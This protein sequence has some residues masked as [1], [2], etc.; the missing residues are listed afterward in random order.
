MTQKKLNKI[1]LGDGDSKIFLMWEQHWLS[2]WD[3]LDD[4]DKKVLAALYWEL[5]SDKQKS[6]F[7]D[8][9]YIDLQK[10]KAAKHAELMSDP[11]K[12]RKN[13]LEGA[14]PLLD[15]MLQL[16]TG[17]KQNKSKDTDSEAWA[18][19]EIW[20]VLKD[21]IIKTDDLAPMLDLKGKSI[22]DQID[23]ILTKVSN[24]QITIADAKEYM[25]LVSAGFNLQ[26]LPKLLATLEK[27]ENK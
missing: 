23:Q 16:A 1:N 9:E 22:D 12:M 4:C 15:D 11:V 24:G 3:S 21:V 5:L 19:R 6:D 7:T 25:A 14:A 17:K 27:L 18:K 8:S 2:D 20:D 13:F 26:Q 10:V